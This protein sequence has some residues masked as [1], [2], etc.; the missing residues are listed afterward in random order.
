MK[1]F[2]WS[3]S[4]LKNYETCPR[5]HNEV[6]N[7]KNFVEEAKPGGPLHWGNA[8]HKALANALKG[9]S[10]LPKEMEAYQKWVDAVLAGPG[11][12]FVEEKYALTRTFEPTPYWAPNVWYRGVGDVV[13]INGDLGLVV[14]WKTGKILEDSVQLFLMA[15]CIFSHFPTVEY[16]RSE[17]IWLKENCTTEEQFS[18]KSVA[19]NW[20]V[21]LDRVRTLEQ[22][23]I[24][25]NYPPKPG[26]LC[27]RYCPVTTCQY[28]GRGSF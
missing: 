15:Q 11:K 9:A 17:Y 3:F 7:L 10:P 13:R 24:D 18:R 1:P 14:D 2:T 27:K 26:R 25:K 6:D 28:H 12:L 19:G 22:A 8:V 4:R 20:L 23:A 16:V 5:R 21:I